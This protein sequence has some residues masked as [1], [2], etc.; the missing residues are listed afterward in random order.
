MPA[1]TMPGRGIDHLVLAVHRLE[2]AAA[3]YQSLGFTVTPQGDHP[4]GTANRLVQLQGSFLEIITVSDPPKI[5]EPGPRQFSFGMYVR[6]TLAK[7][8]GLAML[9]FESADARADRDAF[10]AAGLSDFEPFDFERR[11]VQPDGKA[12]TVGFSLAFVYRPEAPDVAFFTCQQH[13]PAYFWKADYQRH[14]NTARGVG[15]VV[16]IDRD[17]T[18]W[19][20]LM[21]GLQQPDALE[22]DQEAGCL[23]V[24]TAR[25]WVTIM[26]PEAAADWFGPDAFPASRPDG[27]H[28]AAFRVIVDDVARTE[29]LLKARNV[30]ATWS[31][32]GLTV[33]ADTLFG[34]ALSFVQGAASDAAPTAL[35]AAPP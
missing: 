2:E 10:A 14:P 4:W 24:A 13:A 33:A 31:R 32:A 30:A 3:R 15:E 9:V 34:V 26:T 35:L 12:A 8:Q 7:R 28:C 19:R 18:R 11:A 16:L 20:D 25:G 17:P 22:S 1:S 21:A 27:L 29:A 6:D 23:R 5:V